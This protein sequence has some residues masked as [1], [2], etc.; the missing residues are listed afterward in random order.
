M[1]SLGPT[2]ARCWLSFLVDE[3]RAR[4]AGRVLFDAV[5][6]RWSALPEDFTVREE[7]LWKSRDATRSEVVEAEVHCIRSL[8]SNDPAVG[9]NRWPPLGETGSPA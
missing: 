2:I 8:R 5:F 6:S 4:E 3:D 9:Y 1:S 7:I